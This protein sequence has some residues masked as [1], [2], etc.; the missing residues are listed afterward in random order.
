MVVFGW[1]S[2]NSPH[3]RKRRKSKRL[4]GKEKSSLSLILSGSKEIKC[5]GKK[6]KEEGT[7]LVVGQCNISS[8]SPPPSCF[9]FL[10]S[11]SPLAVNL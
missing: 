5:K 7:D 8:S 11:F 1:D 2:M 3:E 10:I 4:H 9:A 6:K